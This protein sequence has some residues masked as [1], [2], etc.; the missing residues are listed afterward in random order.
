ME[1][2]GLQ[3]MSAFAKCYVS[4]PGAEAW[5]DSL[6]ANRIPKTVGRI[7]LCHMLSKN[8]GVRS[9]FTIFR[10]RP[11]GF[12][13]VSAGALERHDH[14]YLMKAAP[15]D[16]SVRVFPVTTAWGVLVLAGPRSRDV[17]QKLTD[18]DLSNKAFPWLTG[19]K[20][21]V[22]HAEALCAAGELRR[23]ARLGAASPDRDAEHDLRPA[24]G[25]G[26]RVRHQA[27]RHPGD[28]VDGDREILPA[29]RARAFDRIFGAANPASTAS[30]T[31]TRGSSSA[32][33]RWSSGSSGGFG[34]KFVTL[35]VHG[36]T[37]ADARGSE[38]IW[39]GDELVGRATNGGYGWRVG[40][41]LAL[42]MVR[43]EHGEIG[44]ELDIQILGERRRATIVAE[45]PYDPENARLR[46]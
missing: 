10:A 3:D 45:S 15:A 6:M 34:W 13:L 46:A 22:G 17:L 26:R 4:G 27:V 38:P 40:K 25:C 8:G 9:E 37:D 18:T 20:I 21:N 23:R 42:A 11:Q 16:G 41:S 33:T 31:R 5:L 43:P 28:D 19:R 35:E 14:D 32:A 39:L 2:V 30:C 24:D 36:V 1:G 29:D 12:Y 44:A 7:N